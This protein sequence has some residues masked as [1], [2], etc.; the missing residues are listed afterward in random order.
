MNP[1]IIT[2]TGRPCRPNDQGSVENM[3]KIVK[4]ALN[5]TLVEWRLGGENPNWT[6]VLGSVSA[7]INAAARHGKNDTPAYTAVYGQT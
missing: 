7:S 4:R 5:S 1:N 6:E 3:N 2:V